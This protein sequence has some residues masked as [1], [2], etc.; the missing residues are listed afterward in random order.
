MRPRDFL[1]SVVS[2]PSS[3]DSTREV[4]VGACNPRR[5]LAIYAV[6]AKSTGC[7]NTHAV[8]KRDFYGGSQTG[9]MKR[10]SA[11]SSGAVVNDSEARMGSEIED[12]DAPGEERVP[13]Q[14]LSPILSAIGFGLR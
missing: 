5:G 13:K 4:P 2:L 7:G 1:E 10:C 14:A 3:T 9:H 8:E 12:D 6:G 11:T